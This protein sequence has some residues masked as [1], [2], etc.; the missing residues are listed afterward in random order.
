[1][2]G[3]WSWR[4]LRLDGRLDGGVNRR[5]CWLRLYRRLWSWSLR[6]RLRIGG[7]GWNAKAV[8][9]ADGA[10]L[11]LIESVIKFSAQRKQLLFVCPGAHH[12]CF[13][14]DQCVVQ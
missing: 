5:W 12:P 1:M 6:C 7:C 2:H 11:R 10:G 3:S 8:Q 9:R 14:S 4:R 13:K